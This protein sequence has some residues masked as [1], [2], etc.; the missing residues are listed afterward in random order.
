[1]AAVNP[2]QRTPRKRPADMTGREKERLAAEAEEAQELEAERMAM[3]TATRAVKNR[4]VVDYT[5][6]A[7]VK[8]EPV[9][10]PEIDVT[11]RVHTI[12]VV[13][14]IEQMTFGRDVIDPGDLSDPDNPRMPTLGSLKF[15]DFEEG[16]QYRV[17]HDLYLHLKS[18]GYLYE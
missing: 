4:A 14:D 3:A 17:D 5:D 12:R 10:V 13:A 11:P 15:Y 16:I 1:M 8:P 2:A 9:P 7:R 18:L 6:A